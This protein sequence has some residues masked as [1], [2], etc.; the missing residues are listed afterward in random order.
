[1]TPSHTHYI[2]TSLLATFRGFAGSFGSA[3]GGGLFQR[4]LYT[5]LEDGF[6]EKGLTH[7]ED[8]VRRLLGSPALVENLRGVD[9]DVAITGYEDALRALFI[10]GAGLALLMV[11]V[12][13]GTGWRGAEEKA[14]ADT[15]S[16]EPIDEN[17]R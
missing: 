1:L 5:S 2:A 11:F 7:K 16:A 3:I 9:R 15:L 12:Q 10:A 8:L 4:T 17:D 13:A 14:K 6:A